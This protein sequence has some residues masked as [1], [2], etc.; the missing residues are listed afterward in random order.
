MGLFVSDNST[1]TLVTSLFDDYLD[2]SNAVVELQT[3]GVP[4]GNIAMVTNFGTATGVETTASH[5]GGASAGCWIFTTPELGTVA[6]TGWLAPGFIRRAFD[7]ETFMTKLRKAGAS[8]LEATRYWTGLRLGQSLVSAWVP[9]DFA[10]PVRDV[11]MRPPSDFSPVGSVGH[12]R[13]D[14]AVSGD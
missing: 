6:V 2:A 1:T 11:L 4:V 3:K 13:L 7:F 14:R 8:E 5:L 10:R 9:E 12:E